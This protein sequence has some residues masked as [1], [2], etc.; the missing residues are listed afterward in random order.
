MLSRRAG[1]SAT[2]G[3]YGAVFATIS[4]LSRYSEQFQSKRPTIDKFWHEKVH[5]GYKTNI[6]CIGNQS[7]LH[8]FH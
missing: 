8:F 7:N 6:S 4:C 5:Y 3:L 1:L 2:A